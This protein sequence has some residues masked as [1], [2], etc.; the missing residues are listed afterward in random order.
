MAISERRRLAFTAITII[1]VGI[2]TGLLLGVAFLSGAPP[3]KTFNV[4]SYH[5]GYALFDE[6]WNEIEQ[7]VVKR[8]TTVR[9]ITYPATLFS[10]ELQEE[11]Y[12]RVV[13]GGL[14]TSSGKDD[15]V[16]EVEYQ[17]GDTKIMD[18]I[19]AARTDPDQADFGVFIEA[20]NVDLSPKTDVS[21]WD[22]A[23]D[24]IEFTPDAM[25]TF[26]LS[27]SIECGPG[28]SFHSLLEALI[29]E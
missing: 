23:I 28:H 19:E 25:G 22:E 9:L 20:F 17:P 11:W 27:C 7:M 15:E 21:T 12:Q 10:Q 14:K 2:I 18:L 24:S 3:I 26:E 8:G 16:V 1:L 5:W 13:D 4:I 29:V 6:D